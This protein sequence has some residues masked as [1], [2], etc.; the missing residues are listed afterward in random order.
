[1]FGTN[2][3]AIEVQRVVALGKIDQSDD[4]VVIDSDRPGVCHP[5]VELHMMKRRVLALHQ[6]GAAYQS[7]NI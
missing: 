2:D 4:P 5:R 1:M 7:L 3:A 6:S